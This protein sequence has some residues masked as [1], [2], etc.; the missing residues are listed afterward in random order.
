V[1]AAW[2]AL[3]DNWEPTRA[4]LHMWTQIVGK[5]RLALAPPQ[6]HFWHSTLYVNAHGLTTSAIPYGA[7]LFQI[8]F[9]FVE[10]M[11]LILTSTGASQR[12]P[13]EPKSVAAFYAELMASL[14]GLGID[15]SIYAR[16][17]EIPDPIPFAE[18]RVHA[19][20]DAAAVERF[21]HALI[22]AD[23]VFTQ[24]RGR[25]LGKSSP[26]HFFWGAFDLAVT[27]FS[28]RR[29]PMWSGQVVNV[30]P[31]VMHASYSHEVS[32]AGFWL[33]SGDSPALFY[34]YAVP[35]PPG[36]REAAVRG[37]YDPRMGEFILPYAD[38]HDDETLHAFLETTYAAAADLGQWDREL[39]EHQ[40]RCTCDPLPA[41]SAV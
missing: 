5:I 12:V 20:Y 11:L 3:P 36:F 4:T 21:W 26:V 37:G 23:R 39:L 25:F 27:R 32:S 16:P 14:R 33:G 40:P 29:A 18:D 28:G 19:D 35:E 2:P 10:H 8:D 31:H 17:V 24:F 15:V 7:E 1:S 22:Q 6:N 41:W 9:D 34:S 38:V 13:L 30:H